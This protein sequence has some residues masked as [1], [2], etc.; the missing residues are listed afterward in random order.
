[1]TN[2][3]LCIRWLRLTTALMGCRAGAGP[4]ERCLPRTSLRHGGLRSVGSL[5]LPL[6]TQTWLQL[7]SAPCLQLRVP[8]QH[9]GQVCPYPRPRRRRHPR[10]R[11]Q[12]CAPRIPPLAPLTAHANYISPAD[13]PR[14]PPRLHRLP[15]QPL[16][17][18]RGRDAHLD[19]RTDTKQAVHQGDQ[20]Y[21]GR[22]RGQGEGVVVYIA[23]MVGR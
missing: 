17:R 14:D 23:L 10:H 22:G 16:L 21:R 13:L 4:D 3:Q 18:R 8:N 12:N 7:T 19:G 15:L 11:R 2:C 1:M 9:A 5:T 6:T 20:D